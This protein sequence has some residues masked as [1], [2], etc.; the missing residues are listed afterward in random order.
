[1]GRVD[2]GTDGALGR[3]LKPSLGY[4]EKGSRLLDGFGKKKNMSQRRDWRDWTS[5]VACT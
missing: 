1:M 2:A 4:R 5:Y 3:E